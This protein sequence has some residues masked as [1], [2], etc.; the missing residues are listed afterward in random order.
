[1]TTIPPNVAEKAREILVRREAARRHLLPYITTFNKTYQAGWVHKDLCAR[2]E[3]FSGQVARGESPRLMVRM[4]PRSGKSEIV[5]RNFPGWHLGHYPTHEIIS[6]SYASALAI[7]FSRKV[8]EIIRE[9]EYGHLFP[10]MQLHPE[11]QNVENWLST[12]DGGYLA[13]GVSG[14]LTGNGAHILIIDDPLKNRE[15]ADSETIR[16]SH[17]EWYTSTAYTRLAPGGGV[18]VI[19]TRW[20]HDDLSG[21]L[22]SEMLE[23]GDQWE[24]ISYPAI[25]EQD[26]RYRKKGEAL[27]PERYP[28]EALERIKRAVGPR[29]WEALYQQR[30]SAEEGS[31]F[32][33]QMFRFYG[34]AE[35][36]PLAEMTKY[37]ACDLAIGQ[38][39]VNDYS[40]MIVVG[41]DRTERIW[42]LDLHR[43][44]WDGFDLVEQI[45]D[46]Y[47]MWRP[48]IAGIERGH[49][50]MALGPFLERRVA[51][52]GLYDFHY[53]PLK[54][55]R[56]DKQ[57]RARPIQARMKQGMVMIPKDEPWTSGLVK[58]LLEFPNGAHDDMVDTLAWIGQL[59]QKFSTV[60]LIEAVAPSWRDKID[61]ILNR[62][63]SGS[64]AMGA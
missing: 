20:H 19:M 10:E 64:T 55:G 21:W 54:T 40:V 61:Q 15:E 8:R 42:L 28:L 37:M 36:P 24:I 17:K 49:I 9:E 16:Q 23:G 57:A 25:A 4:P 3:R 2:L 26:E 43:G 5:S 51:E 12:Q 11:F 63:S 45:L 52:R 60:P 62:R 31:Y 58:E 27:H 44:R 35:L 59:Q 1:M 41:V 30:P 53:E 6:T 56:S 39:D 14:P 47:Q 18:I 38:R 22:E 46:I 33:R 32:T 48:E 34:P 50:E 7:K 29:D 13:A